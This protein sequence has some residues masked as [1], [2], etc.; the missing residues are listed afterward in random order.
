MLWA[1][2]KDFGSS[3]FRLG[4]LYSQN[5]QFMAAMANI[6]IFTGVSNPVQAL[7]TDVMNNKDGWVDTFLDESR[8]RLRR[9]YQICTT[10]LDGLG[11]PY[12]EAQAG[13]FMYIDLSSLLP[14]KTFEEEAKLCDLVADKA[15]IVLTPGESQRENRPGMFRI[16]YAW[17]SVEVL[18]IAMDRLGKVLKSVQDERA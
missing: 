8:T 2:S 14:E 10:M 5:A 7:A 12:V 9:S 15:K 16:C 4:T 6:N 3:G 18:Q 1:F 11:I 17:V 13:L